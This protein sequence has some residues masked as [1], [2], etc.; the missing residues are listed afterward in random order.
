MPD[1]DDV[2]WSPDEFRELFGEIPAAVR[3]PL[4]Q[5]C[6]LALRDGLTRQEVIDAYGRDHP[7]VVEAA[8]GIAVLR[9]GGRN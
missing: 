5:V 8:K 3:A 4:R 9:D 7:E 6:N 2:P 1:N